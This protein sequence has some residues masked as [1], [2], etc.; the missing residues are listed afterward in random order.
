[1]KR[2]LIV[3]SMNVVFTHSYAISFKERGFN[4][5]VLDVGDSIINSH[6][7]ESRGVN[8]TRWRNSSFSIDKVSLSQRIKKIFKRIFVLLALDRS[9]TVLMLIDKFEKLL[10]KKSKL[11]EHISIE[12]INEP[13]DYVFYI[14]ST[15]VRRYKILIDDF[16]SHEQINQSPRSIL[17][18]NTYPVRDNY[19]FDCPPEMCDQDKKYFKGFDLLLFPSRVMV[20]LF[21]RMGLACSKHLIH[22]DLLHPNYLVFSN[23]GACTNKKKKRILFL[24]NT[25]FS[26]RTIDN[27]LPYLLKLAESGIEVCLQRSSNSSQL[28]ENFNYF[29]PL[30]YE[31]FLEGELA[32]F[33]SGFDGVFMG[34]NDM[35]NARSRSSFP[36]RFALALIGLKPILLDGQDFDGLFEEF[37]G[38]NLLKKYSSID[39]L[40]LKIKSLSSS[41][42]EFSRE[43]YSQRFHN[44]FDQLLISMGEEI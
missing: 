1:M 40:I 23:N 18:I 17:A 7:L 8:V 43:K 25:N 21:E 34:Y 12:L 5:R 30:S 24:G 22:E 6:F 10:S 15:T 9:N 39:D 29:T 28:H 32:N 2:I 3:A 31:A 38:T 27:V 4:V 41:P 26:E 14:W 35:R 36:T 33:I 37:S 42:S 11:P 16:F 44:H 20:D 13:N 19:S